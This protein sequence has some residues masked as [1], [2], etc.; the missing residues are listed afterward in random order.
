MYAI[1][2]WL[3]YCSRSKETY[4]QTH[5][6]HN[7]PE[8]KWQQKKVVCVPNQSFLHSIARN[9]QP[10]LA[11]CHRAKLSPERHARSKPGRFTYNCQLEAL[12]GLSGQAQQQQGCN[13]VQ[14]SK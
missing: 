12:P 1:I 2:D 8:G 4:T 11:M 14:N 3:A 9:Q 5:N 10:D 13:M 6:D 7:C